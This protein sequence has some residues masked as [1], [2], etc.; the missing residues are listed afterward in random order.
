V[1]GIPSADI[2]PPPAGDGIVDSNDLAVLTGS[3]L[4]APTRPLPGEVSNPNPTDFALGVDINSDLSWSAGFDATSYDVYFGTNSPG[5][6]QGNQTATT[7]EPGTM[8]F[9]TIHYWRIDT[10]NSWGKTKGEVWRFT[11]MSSP[12]P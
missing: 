4:T 8:S 12:P 9:S 3:W 1:P 11:T 7:F 2:A 10:V 6:F 5:T